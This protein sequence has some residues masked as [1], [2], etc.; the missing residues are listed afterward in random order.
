MLSHARVT[1][2][3]PDNFRYA[4]PRRRRRPPVLHRLIQPRDSFGLLVVVRQL[5]VQLRGEP[6]AETPRQSLVS[7]NSILSLPK[8]PSMRALS[9]ALARHGAHRRRS[10]IDAK[11]R[12]W[13]WP[14]RSCQDEGSRGRHAA[15]RPGSVAAAR[16]GRYPPPR[17]GP[18]VAVE[19][20]GQVHPGAARQRELGHVGHPQPVG[21]VG[22]EVVRPVLPQGHVG[23][24][25]DV[26]GRPS[27]A[28]GRRL[29]PAGPP[30]A[31]RGARASRT[32][33]Q[34]S[35]LTR[36]QPNR[37][38]GARL[39]DPIL[40]SRPGPRR[41]PLPEPVEVGRAETKRR[42]QKADR[43]RSPRRGGLPAQGVD[44]GRLLPVG[45]GPR[46]GARAFFQ[47]VHRRPGEVDLELHVEDDALELPEVVE[48]V[49][50]RAFR[51]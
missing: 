14:P 31:S 42:C 24:L 35:R 45:E 16:R 9:V 21:G 44:Q 28:V 10:Q 15:S 19:D 38:R 26:L 34:C 51:P 47:D 5:A 39:G 23:Q 18:V 17:Q 32:P 3:V 43:I 20:G 22:E 49:A 7:K 11:L 36:L 13:Y 48:E 8:N 2:D 41:P 40:M 4:L 37:V 30:G 1:R 46:V 6:S 27:S 29:A 33:P 25:G 50:E 12:A